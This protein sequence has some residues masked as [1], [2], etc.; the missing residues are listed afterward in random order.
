MINIPAGQLCIDVHKS[1]QNVT[2]FDTIMSGLMPPDSKHDVETLAI[3]T[4]R[5]RC[6]GFIRDV[7]FLFALTKKGKTPLSVLSKVEGFKK[8][9]MNID[10]FEEAKS[11]ADNCEN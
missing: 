8:L 10:T 6:S 5:M 7:E 2:S 1:L 11:L 4:A 3:E 9:K